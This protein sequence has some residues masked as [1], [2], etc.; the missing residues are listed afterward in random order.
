MMSYCS[1]EIGQF[2]NLKTQSLN[3]RKINILLS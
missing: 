3:E 2:T 1:F